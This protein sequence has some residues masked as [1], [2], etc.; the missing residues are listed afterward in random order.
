MNSPTT[1]YFGRWDLPA[2]SKTEYS[3]PNLLSALQDCNQAIKEDSEIGYAYYVRG[4]IKKLLEKEDYCKDLKRA[5]SLDYQFDESI[6][7]NCR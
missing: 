4:A 2:Q 5:K 7:E 1:M 3:K 6:L